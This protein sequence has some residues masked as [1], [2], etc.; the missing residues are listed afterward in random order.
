MEISKGGVFIIG[1]L[2]GKAKNKESGATELIS[3][4]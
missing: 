4:T 1:K 2:V 3:K